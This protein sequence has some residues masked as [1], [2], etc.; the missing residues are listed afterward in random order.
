MDY[1]SLIPA[2][3]VVSS[4]GS[5][6]GKDRRTGWGWISILISPEWFLLP[7]FWAGDFALIPGGWWFWRLFFCS[8][9]FGSV[10]LP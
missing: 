4:V 10:I 2:R 5:V 3:D 9:C 7:L 8:S 1:V 6:T